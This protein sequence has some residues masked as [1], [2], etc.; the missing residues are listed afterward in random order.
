MTLPRATPDPDPGKCNRFRSEAGTP[1]LSSDIPRLSRARAQSLA[2]A[3]GRFTAL[4]TSFRSFRAFID[5]LLTGP[6]PDLDSIDAAEAL[7]ELRADA[8]A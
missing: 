2:V 4:S 7:R 1:T 8:S 3:E 6:D 5:D